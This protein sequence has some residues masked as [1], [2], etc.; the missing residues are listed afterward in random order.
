MWLTGHKVQ[1]LMPLGQLPEPMCSDEIQIIL[2]GLQFIEGQGKC[3]TLTT[4]RK[5]RSKLSTFQSGYLLLDTCQLS[6]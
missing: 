1:L 2:S 6:S 3:F 4:T 5:Y